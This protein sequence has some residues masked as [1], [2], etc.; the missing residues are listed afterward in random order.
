L[1]NRKLEIKASKKALN[2]YSKVANLHALIANIRQD[3]TQKMTT[4]ISRKAYIIR[5]EDLNIQGMI[6]NHKLAAAVSN[7][8]LQEIR[9][10]LTYKQAH[11]GTKVEL[12]DRWYPSSKMCSQCDHI[13]PMKLSERIFKCGKCGANQ[14]RDANAAINLERAPNNKVLLMLSRNLTPVDKQMPTSLDEA[15][16]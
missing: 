13:Q 11:Y 10:Q 16:K 14:D 9:R 3:T 12:V 2:F 5:I 4:D 1:G 15:G 8:A 6:A 7:N